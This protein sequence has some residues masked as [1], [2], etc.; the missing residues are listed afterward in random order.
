MQQVLEPQLWCFIRPDCA[1]NQ[2]FTRSMK[3]QAGKQPASLCWPHAV[4]YH[5]S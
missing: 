5:L 3:G 2:N 1:S 4:S